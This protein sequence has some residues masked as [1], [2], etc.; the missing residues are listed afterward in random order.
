MGNRACRAAGP[1]QDDHALGGELIASVVVFWTLFYL[2]VIRLLRFPRAEF[3]LHVPL[4]TAIAASASLLWLAAGISLVVRHSGGLYL[5][6]PGVIVGTIVNVI[7]AWS[8]LMGTE[9]D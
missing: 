4:R 6:L 2:P 3:E 9:S 7:G 5:L 1:R 8:I